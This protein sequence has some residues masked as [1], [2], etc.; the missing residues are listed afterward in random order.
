M[1]MSEESFR[2]KFL[3]NLGLLCAAQVRTSTWT[4]RVRCDLARFLIWDIV[5]FVTFFVSFKC[6]IGC[7]SDSS[8]TQNA[9]NG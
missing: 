8:V 4:G 3:W 7:V 1:K 6:V 5:V 9:L 2:K